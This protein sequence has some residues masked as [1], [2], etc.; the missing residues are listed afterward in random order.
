MRARRPFRPDTFPFLAVLLCAMGSLILLLL[1]MDR[2]AKA[3]A[4]AKAERAVARATQADAEAE[5]ARQSEWERRCQALHAA[6]TQQDESVRGELRTLQG[7]MADAVA[8]AAAGEARTRDL[9]QRAQAEQAGIRHGQQEVAA[10]RAEL[11]RAQQQ[12]IAAQEEMLTLMRELESLEQALTDLKAARQREQRTYSLVP[13]RGK[14]GD[15]R[16]PLY[17]ECAGAG[18][19]FHPDKLALNGIDMTPAAVRAEVKKRVDRQRETLVKTAAKADSDKPPYLLFLVRPDGIRRYYE[20]MA[21]LDGLQI[22]FGYE[23]VDPDWILDFPDTDGP[24]GAQPWM[25]AGASPVPSADRPAAQRPAVVPA[26]RGNG[27]LT[28]GGDRAG[29]ASGAP[30]DGPGANGA[31]VAAPTGAAPSGKPGVRAAPISVASGQG[32]PGGVPGASG[33]AG[34]SPVGPGAP[35][36]GQP[37]VAPSGVPGGVP[38]SPGP[39]TG[40]AATNAG[41]SGHG[42]NLS[43]RGQP[44]DVSPDGPPVGTTGVGVAGQPG[45]NA[46]RTAPPTASGPG[47]PPG[48]AGTSAP[49]PASAA[50][51]PGPHGG[52]GTTAGTGA[53]A[54]AQN[55]GKTPDGLERMGGGTSDSTSE[56]GSRA[57][58]ALPPQLAPLPGKAPRSPTGPRPQ[59]G[60]SR[61]WFV[62]VECRGDAVV[63]YPGGRRFTPAALGTSEAN[64]LVQAVQ[65]LAARRQAMVRAGELPYRVQI[66]FLVRP[67][68]LSTYYRAYPV[69]EAVQLPMTRRNLD[70]DEEVR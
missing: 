17:V 59:F 20:A 35:L 25:T 45:G 42:V 50:G 27:R 13:Y 48:P 5:A 4:R 69:L 62:L 8:K 63:L 23:F 61:D 21:A 18:L 64:A 67:D 38:G 3:V 37:V 54:M 10:R 34:G 68:G 60:P 40:D 51:A 7:R 9:Q 58:S 70:A 43:G 11:V 2:R 57:G 39:S 44:P 30:G 41:P 52:P 55:A 56:P 46:A 1:V 66:R 65:D 16:R 28:F 12:T 31:G 33:S 32:V 15:S 24:A 29:G 47:S 6:L 53:A 19:V 36:S 26:P 49:A 14:R 22:D